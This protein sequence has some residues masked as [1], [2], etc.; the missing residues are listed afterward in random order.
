MQYVIILLSFSNNL[1][2]FP[3][4]NILTLLLG[5]NT[6]SVAAILVCFLEPTMRLAIEHI[7]RMKGG[8]Q[9][10]L[11]RADDGACYVVKFKNN[12]Q[13]L[14]TLA[15][16]MF[17]TRLAARM[18][19]C[20][21]QVDVVEVR[22]S[23]IE[24]TPELVM[25]MRVGRQPCSAGNQF[26]SKF[27]GNPSSL[28][29]YEFLPDEHLDR[30][31]NLE[32]FLG[33][34]VF[35]KWTCNTDKRQA[36]FVPQSNTDSDVTSDKLYQAMMIDHGYCF[37]GEKWN[38]PDAPLLNLYSNRRVYQGVMGIEAFDPWLDRLEN[39]FTLNALCEEAQ[40]VPT[41][42]YGGDQGAWELLIERL[43]V[44]RTRVRELIWLAQKAVNDTF[45][46]WRKR[47]HTLTAT[48]TK[49]GTTEVAGIVNSGD[50]D[51]LLSHSSAS[52][53]ARLPQREL[54]VPCS[55]ASRRE[56]PTSA[57]CK[58]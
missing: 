38:F 53:C 50:A 26:G 40:Q 52:L 9:A 42:W 57:C 32:D 23:L 28:T 6:L 27:P 1:Q 34:Y 11:M 14:R 7:R 19:I 35:D 33:I 44:R 13:H 49:L 5:A 24:Y 17:A 37:N 18:G 45:P 12:P 3:Y 41:E 16:E 54:P 39:C 30:V 56:P 48:K 31:R 55:R 51:L 21:P 22:P 25:Q 43:Y 4:G 58:R 46:N 10:H 36:I 20:V 15:N 8:A 29:I 2:E 47:V